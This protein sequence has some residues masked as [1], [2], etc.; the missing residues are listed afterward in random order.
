MH[1]KR[2]RLG[3]KT[4]GE[5]EQSH[6]KLKR[7]IPSDL[8]R[9]EAVS[10]TGVGGRQEVADAGQRARGDD[11]TF[12]VKT[13]VVAPRPR[14]RDLVPSPPERARNPDRKETDR[15]IS[16][17]EQIREVRVVKAEGQARTHRRCTRVAAATNSTTIFTTVRLHYGQGCT[18]P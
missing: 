6:S 12:S 15:F 16:G 17:E 13:V 18:A 14:A 10:Q 7:E 3:F 8:L 11:A 5:S 2:R 4:R 9:E 1:S